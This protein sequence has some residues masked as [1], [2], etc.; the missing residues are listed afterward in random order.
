MYV[1]VTTSRT[2]FMK[3]VKGPTALLVLKH[4]VV[5][6]VICGYLVIYLL[7]AGPAMHYSQKNINLFKA[8]CSKLL[9]FEGF[10]TRE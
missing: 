8:R 10:S 1:Q 4:I 7:A 2:V 9:L 5:V 3:Q 6:V